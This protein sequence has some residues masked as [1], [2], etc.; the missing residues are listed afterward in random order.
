MGALRA[1][2][3]GCGSIC[4]HWLT[5]IAK[6]DDVEIVG[7]VDVDKHAADA[8]KDDFSLEQAATGT[9]LAEMLAHTKPDAVFDCT[10]PPAHVDVALTAMDYNCHV[11]G[12]KPLA[13]TLE[14][15]QKIVS[16][17]QE[18]GLVHAVVQ[19]RRFDP[20]L[21]KF[22]DTLSDGNYGKLTTLNCDF[23]LG[24]H[25][26]G[27]RT[28][29]QHVLLLD[30]AIH[31][32]DAARAITGADAKSVYCHEWNPEGSWYA[33]GASAVAIF[34]MSDGSVFNYRG[35]WCAEGLNTT[36]ESAWHAVCTKGSI[37]WDG[38]ESCLAGKV[39]DSSGFMS[40]CEDG[41]VG[42]PEVMG[43]DGHYAVLRDFVESLESGRTPATDCKDNIKSLSMVEKAVESAEKQEKVSISGLF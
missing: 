15:A 37:K 43:F 17:S 34:E 21:K 13:D 33:H 14:N 22:R 25:F 16:K 23:Y 18:K 7:L 36:W 5:Q 3:A 42:M 26:G 4:G 40:V 10:T 41:T 11:L 9:D 1:V 38:A 6:M 29:M 39:K 8:K 31:T 12:E 27:F 30:M 32:F 19:N 24:A 35:S 2:I 28:E 20:R